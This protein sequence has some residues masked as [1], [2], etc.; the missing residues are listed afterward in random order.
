MC[1]D[2]RCKGRMHQWRRKPCNCEVRKS[3]VHGA[4]NGLFA[5]RLYKQ[6]EFVTY[7]AGTYSSN[8]NGPRVLQVDEDTYVDAAGPCKPGTALGDYINHSRRRRNCKFIVETGTNNNKK[9]LVRVMTT[10]NVYPG[11]ELLG[12]YGAMVV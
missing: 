5:D 9:K 4:G 11:Q 3:T 7:Y 12:D 1:Q 6:G 8:T 10:R 2:G